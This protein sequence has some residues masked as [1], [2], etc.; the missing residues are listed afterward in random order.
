[1]ISLAQYPLRNGL[2]A[3][4][5]VMLRNPVVKHLHK[6]CLQYLGTWQTVIK[7]VII[8]LLFF[9]TRSASK[10]I[11]QLE[12]LNTI[13]VV[14]VVE[15]GAGNVRADN[16]FTS[17]TNVSFTRS[18]GLVLY[19]LAA[20]ALFGCPVIDLITRKSEHKVIITTV[21]FRAI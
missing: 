21:D 20:L 18:L 13:D 1:M 4:A 2:D 16:R 14:T 17:Q 7:F 3:N 5:S 15:L 8:V 12:E 10:A 11:I 19:R 6:V 9:S